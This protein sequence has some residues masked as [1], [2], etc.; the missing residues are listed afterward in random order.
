MREEQLTINPMS[1]GAFMDMFMLNPL[2][3]LIQY[4]KHSVVPAHIERMKQWNI[5]IKDVVEM[6]KKD[7]TIHFDEALMYL[8]I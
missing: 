3:A 1:D 5:D 6:K 2:Q 7:N 8:Y 4:F